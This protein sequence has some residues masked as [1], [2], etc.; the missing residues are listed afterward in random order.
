[1]PY[2]SDPARI[3]VRAFLAFP[4]FLVLKDG[5]HSYSGL[6]RTRSPPRRTGDS[7]PPCDE[8]ERCQDS[9]CVRQ[10]LL[11]LRCHY[12]RGCIP[13]AQPCLGGR[14][15]GARVLSMLYSSSAVN[16]DAIMRVTKAY[17]L[18][19][20]DVIGGDHQDGII[21]DWRGVGATIRVQGHT[22]TEYADPD[23]A[24]VG[25]A[26]GCETSSQYIECKDKAK[27]TIH[28]KATK[29]YTWGHRNHSLN[30]VIFI[31]GEY[32]KG[33]L[34]R[35]GDTLFQPWEREFAIAPSRSS[36]MGFCL[37]NETTPLIHPTGN[38][39]GTHYHTNGHTIGPCVQPA[40]NGNTSGA[41]DASHRMVGEEANFYRLEKLPHT[42]WFENLQSP[43][44]IARLASDPGE[45]PSREA[46]AKEQLTKALLVLY[47]A[48]VVIEDDVLSYHRCSGQHQQRT[49][50]GQHQRRAGHWQHFFS[51]TITSPITNPS[52]LETQVNPE[53]EGS[54]PQSKH[55]HCLRSVG[56]QCRG[57][58]GRDTGCSSDF[59]LEQWLDLN[60][61]AD[62]D[63]FEDNNESS[64]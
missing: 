7:V 19:V 64:F 11:R 9:G 46:F 61:N 45:T 33:K 47:G 28:L 59:E 29:D 58:T 49:S 43:I 62:D 17:A 18:L 53:D 54:L 30:I 37:I 23:A 40:A 44:T 6:C 14:F 31:D 60:P 55:F 4:Q 16:K 26:G 56:C 36:W 39:N 5:V 8:D 15:L 63:V 12:E 24:A 2:R 42:M 35:E 34:S 50:R 57:T 38:G 48:G 41:A 10:R 25:N 32:A 27:S 13:G 1:M 51:I 20:Q 52:L 21:D 22:P 3:N